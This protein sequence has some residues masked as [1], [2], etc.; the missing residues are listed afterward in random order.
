MA[1]TSLPITNTRRQ[2]EIAAV[3]LTGIGKFVFMDWLAWK[4][5]FIS[6]AIIAWLAYV[7]IRHRQVPGI[8][9]YWGFRK[10]NFMDVL[11][12]VLPFGISCNR[13]C[14]R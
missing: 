4:L 8:L 6:I 14:G 13:R 11:R 7:L 9:K 1:N 10:D 5:P 2:L 3:V 12:I